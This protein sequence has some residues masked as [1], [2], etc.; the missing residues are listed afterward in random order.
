MD[1]ENNYN[2]LELYIFIHFSSRNFRGIFSW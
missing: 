1:Y 2:L